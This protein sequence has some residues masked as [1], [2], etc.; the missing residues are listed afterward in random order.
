MGTA[1][2]I[3]ALAHDQLGNGGARYW[4]WYTQN[5]RPSQGSFVHGNVTP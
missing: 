3:L 2:D 4:D 5:V 1:A